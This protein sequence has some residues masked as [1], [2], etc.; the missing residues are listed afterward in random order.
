MKTNSRIA[1]G[2]VAAGI[3]TAGFW[4]SPAIAQQAETPLHEQLI[5]GMRGLFGKVF[6][7]S[8]GSAGAEAQPPASQ[9]ISQPAPQPAAQVAG[10][11]LHEA[12]V[13]GDY[14]ATLKLLAEGSDIEAK[15]SGSGASALHYAVMKGRMQI[16]DL[17]LARGADVN[18]RT[19]NGTTPLHT[20]ALYARKEVA[21]RLL[22]KNADMY[23]RIFTKLG[24]TA[25]NVCMVGNSVRNDVL[26]VLSLGGTAVHIPYPLLW[27]LEHIEPMKPGQHSGRFA[28][29]TSITEL[30]EWLG[31]PR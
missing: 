22:E 11:S 25:T 7:G 17:L 31:L 23:D 5:E 27:E 21:E 15:D 4:V 20:A 24:V 18:S 6:G 2:L 12:V 8:A 30:P 1:A 29:L 28:E 9:P 26:P 19:R 14:D 10:L 3:G 13:R 16:V